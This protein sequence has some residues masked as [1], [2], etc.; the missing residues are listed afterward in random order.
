MYDVG[1][2]SQSTSLQ[3]SG[4]VS[5]EASQDGGGTMR[6][7]TEQG[8]DESNDIG[9]SITEQVGKESESTTLN[10]DFGRI[11]ESRARQSSEQKKVGTHS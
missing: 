11:S 7:H 8:V 6:A 10:G 5:A 4:T 1:S 9:G 3:G 2:A